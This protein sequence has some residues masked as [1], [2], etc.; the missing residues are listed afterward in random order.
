MTSGYGLKVGTLIVSRFS[1]SSTM[2]AWSKYSPRYPCEIPCMNLPTAFVLAVLA[3]STMISPP[4][5][6]MSASLTADMVPYRSCHGSSFT[7]F[8]AFT[9][10]LFHAARGSADSSSWPK[11]ANP[12][13]ISQAM[14]DNAH[15]G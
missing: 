10:L 13:V 1:F 14:V 9:G 8:L 12:D 7:S 6:A 5:M 2:N 15:D 4:S 11:S 3:V